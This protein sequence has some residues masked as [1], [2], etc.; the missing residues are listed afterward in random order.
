V[1]S[2]TTSCDR[3]SSRPVR[4]QASEGA[5]QAFE[6][7]IDPP[8]TAAAGPD[9]FDKFAGVSHLVRRRSMVLS[10]RILLENLR[11]RRV[12]SRLANSSIGCLRSEGFKGARVAAPIAVEQ[13]QRG[14]N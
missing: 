8:A 10:L 9:A 13:P 12:S 14:I 5:L 6:R 4:K 11:T 3:T 7:A 1:A 2:A